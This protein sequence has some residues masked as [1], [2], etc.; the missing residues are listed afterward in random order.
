MQAA[1]PDKDIGALTVT[2]HQAGPGHYVADALL[3][4]PDGRLAAHRDRPRLGLRRVLREGGGAGAMRSDRGARSMTRRIAVAAAAFGALAVPAAAQAHVTVQPTSAPAGAQTVLDGAGAQRARRRVDGEG[5]RAAAAAGSRRRRRRRSRAGRCGRRRRSWPRRS[6]PTTARSTSRS[7]RSSGPR[8][9]ARTASR[10]GAV[11]RL[12]AVGRDPGQGR[13][14]RSRSRRCRP[15]ATATSCA[16][17]ARPTPTSPPRGCSSPRRRAA[18]RLPPVSRRTRR[19][20]R[21]ARAR[22]T[23]AARTR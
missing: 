8:R 12:P 23:A 18:A 1:L 22:T 7:A 3:A 19:R 20:R 16:G 15:T 10:P 4:R 21:P 17:S 9:A 13:A 14:R 2:M 6:R 11:P 5:R